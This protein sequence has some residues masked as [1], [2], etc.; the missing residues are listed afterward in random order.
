MFSRRRRS[1]VRYRRTTWHRRVRSAAARPDRVTPNGP[2]TTAAGP[3]TR[4]GGD[5][6]TTRHRVP[7]ARHRIVFAGRVSA[8]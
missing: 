5:S 1:R 3:V 8:V 6:N 7:P 2:P 4:R